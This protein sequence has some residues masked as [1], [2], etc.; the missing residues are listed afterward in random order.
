MNKLIQWSFAAL[1]LAD[2]AILA[3]L[4]VALVSP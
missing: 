3:W 2:A 1:M 4:V